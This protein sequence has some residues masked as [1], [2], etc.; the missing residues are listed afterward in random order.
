MFKFTIIIAGSLNCAMGANPTISPRYS[1][2]RDLKHL[3]KKINRGIFLTWGD[4]LG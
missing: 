1:Y 3:H 4:E 2:R